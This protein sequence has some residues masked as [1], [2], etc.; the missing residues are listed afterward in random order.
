MS[1][2]FEK[3]SAKISYKSTEAIQK[4]EILFDKMSFTTN[5]FD[6]II[7]IFLTEFV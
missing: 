4:K 3:K 1:P 5:N 2:D 7:H 6:N